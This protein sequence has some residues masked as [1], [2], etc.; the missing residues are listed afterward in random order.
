MVEHG[1][2]MV[3]LGSIT[4]GMPLLIGLVLTL[5]D[6]CHEHW[7]DQAAF[8]TIHGWVSSVASTSNRIWTS[9]V[10]PYIQMV[11]HNVPPDHPGQIT[12]GVPDELYIARIMIPR[13]T[14]FG[15]WTGWANVDHKAGES[16][17]FTEYYRHHL[18]TDAPGS[19][20]LLLLMLYLGSIGQIMEGSFIMSSASALQSPLSNTTTLRE[21]FGGWTQQAVCVIQLGTCGWLGLCLAVA[22]ATV[23]SMVGTTETIFLDILVISANVLFSGMTMVPLIG[24]L[25]LYK[26]QDNDELAIE[27]YAENSAWLGRVAK[28]EKMYAVVRWPTII[29]ATVLPLVCVRT[30]L[31]SCCRIRRDFCRPRAD[32]NFRK[33]HKWFENV[34]LQSS[35]L[36]QLQDMATSPVAAEVAVKLDAA[37]IKA[38]AFWMESQ[39]E[40]EGATMKRAAINAA[41]AQAALF[42]VTLFMWAFVAATIATLLAEVTTSTVYPWS[43]GLRACLLRVVWAAQPW[44]CVMLAALHLL[45]VYVVFGA[46]V[47]LADIGRKPSKV[48]SA[49]DPIERRPPQRGPGDEPGNYPSLE[50]PLIDQGMD[51]LSEVDAPKPYYHPDDVDSI[52]TAHRDFNRACN[53]EANFMIQGLTLTHYFFLHPVAEGYFF[54]KDEDGRPER[55]LPALDP[56]RFVSSEQM[57]PRNL[58]YSHL[59]HHG[60][61]EAAAKF[62]EDDWDPGPRRMDKFAVLEYLLF[63]IHAS[64]TEVSAIPMYGPDAEPWNPRPGDLVTVP[65]MG[66]TGKV[67]RVHV[68]IF[69]RGATPQAG[70]QMTVDVELDQR[71]GHPSGTVNGERHVVV[72]RD[73]DRVAVRLERHF[74][75]LVLKII[76][77][78]FMREGPSIMFQLVRTKNRQPRRAFNIDDTEEEF[79]DEENVFPEI[80]MSFVAIQRAAQI[81]MRRLM[82]QQLALRRNLDF[83][84]IDR[85]VPTATLETQRNVIAFFGT[86][87]TAWV[88]QGFAHCSVRGDHQ[89][90]ERE[91]NERAME[92]WAMER[93]GDLHPSVLYQSSAPPK[94]AFG[95][96]DGHSKLDDM[97]MCMMVV[98]SHYLTEDVPETFSLRKDLRA[99][100]ADVAHVKLSS[101]PPPVKGCARINMKIRTDYADPGPKSGPGSSIASQTPKYERPKIQH[102]KD[103]LRDMVVAE[104]ADSLYATW[105]RLNAGDDHLSP[106]EVIGVKNSFLEQEHPDGDVLQES[107]IFQVLINVKYQPRVNGGDR[108]TFGQ[109]AQD[110]QRLDDACRKAKEHAKKEEAFGWDANIVSDYF[111]AALQLL[112]NPP[113]A[114]ATELVT[115]IGEIQ[116][117]HADVYALRKDTHLFFKILRAKTFR[118]L[119][120]DTGIR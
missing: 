50:E 68:E 62:L 76:S 55:M 23:F 3:V 85:I 44:I 37:N 102:V 54:D 61:V 11:L 47:P 75:T 29:M 28:Q 16:Q 33:E 31:V 87:F 72:S 118:D 114:L 100:I 99:A 41:S 52:A 15:P 81:H 119:W 25:V 105:N 7:P 77:K 6:F 45:G 82:L 88:E 59:L 71:T 13:D 8:C 60:T 111:D 14:D 2:A 80:E 94:S 27:S 92:R 49:P 51:P 43:L 86:R 42:D 79:V 65:D 115:I 120:L 32:A 108:L 112:R 21:D 113:P 58:P 104:T 10:A 98:L 30:A 78:V 110:E 103:P 40:K 12:R 83:S 84:Q 36:S 69:V 56:H 17:G 24:C 22:V 64:C 106:F 48:Y 1:A 67:K 90:L 18:F 101:T 117:Y 70:Q 39:F 66:C 5:V 35:A 38:R 46:R 20:K 53:A 26:D 116:L 9:S 107:T 4:L 73:R 19:V 93:T 96:Y 34:F 109:V 95:I 63:A 97:L 89:A 57:S 74:K 91:A